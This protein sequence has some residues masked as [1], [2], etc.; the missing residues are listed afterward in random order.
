MQNNDEGPLALDSLSL[1]ALAPELSKYQQEPPQMASA[2]VGKHGYLRLRFAHSGAKSILHE[3][4]RKVPLLVQKALYWDEEMP[5]LPCVPIISTSGCILQGDR[6]TVE[7]IVDA[8]ACAHVTTQSATKIHS[9]DNNFA[10][11]TQHIRTGKQAYL[12]FMPDPVI[13]HRDSRFI[14]DTVIEC[15]RTATVIYSEILM[16]GRKH[17]HQDER[18]GFDV[19]SSRITVKNEIGSILFTEKLVLTPKQKPLDVVGV[20][21]VFD[22]YGNAIVLTP[23]ANQDEII[24]LSPSF[25]SEQ[26]CYG[27]SRLPNESGLIFKA[28]SCDSTGVKSAIR[29]F[30]EK[31]R[32]VSTGY[33]LPTPFLW[34]I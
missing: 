16:S 4:K 2:S 33:S 32:K 11:Q 19:Y 9:M 12:E 22:V 27:V 26:L 25:Y 18:F 31:V 13:P 6:L 23:K 17:H 21:G 10:A 7:I 14:S 3:M 34:K 24:A 28:L 29:A 30:W 20:M 8:G 1:G 15:D 5:F